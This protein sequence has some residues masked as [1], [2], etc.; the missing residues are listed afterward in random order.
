[1]KKTKIKMNKPVYLGL[2]I[3][4]ISKTLMYKF[5]YNYM[6]PKYQKNVK[7][8]YTDTDSFTINIKTNDFYEDIAYDVEKRLDTSNYECNRP[9]PT[10]KKLKSNWNMKDEVGGKII[11]EFVAL[12]PKTYSLNLMDYG[13]TNKKAKGT[14]NCV[15]KRILKFNGYKNCLLNNKVILK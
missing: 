13:N 3:L 15:T 12:R 10:G 14:K 9:L 7:L 8:C 5:W 1:M 11:T 6:K 2:S 4:E